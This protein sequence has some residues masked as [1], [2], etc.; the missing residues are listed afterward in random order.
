VASPIDCDTLRHSLNFP[1]HLRG[2][3]A[4]GVDV[5]GTVGD[6]RTWVSSHHTKR[7][8]GQG[9]KHIFWYLSTRPC[10]T[11]FDRTLTP[12]RIQKDGLL[13]H[14]DSDS[15]LNPQEINFVSSSS[16]V[17]LFLHPFEEE[18]GHKSCSTEPQMFR[19]LWAPVPTHN[20]TGLHPSMH[21]I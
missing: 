11:A 6:Q 1:A 18:S 21:M 10:P 8:R 19:T 16:S 14:P 15:I 17:V 9:V 2:H 12:F 13:S 4:H 7:R 20:P 3:E 5:G